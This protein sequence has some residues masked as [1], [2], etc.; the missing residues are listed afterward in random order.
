M[1]ANNNSNNVQNTA[2]GYGTGGYHAQMINHGAVPGSRPGRPTM[3]LDHE[4][5]ERLEKALSI[6]HNYQLLM[7]FATENKQVSLSGL[8]ALDRL[9][10]HLCS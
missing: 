1:S 10:A 5:R 4:R 8:I 6:L 3:D 9:I 7:K 2:T